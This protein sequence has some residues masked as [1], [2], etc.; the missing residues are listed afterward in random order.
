MMMSVSEFHMVTIVTERI[1]KDDIL[2]LMRSFGARGFTLTDAEGEGSRGVR[3]SDWEGENVKIESIV[4]AEKAERIMKAVAE[5]YFENYAVI[6][7]S[8]QV[9]VFRGDKYT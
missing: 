7:Y 6:A 4:G 8:Y 1:L 5:T 2:E 9:R 3:A